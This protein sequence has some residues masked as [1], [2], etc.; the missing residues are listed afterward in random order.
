MLLV[1]EES[2]VVAIQSTTIH[3]YAHSVS[4]QN[5]GLDCDE[6]LLARYFMIS[7]VDRDPPRSF[8]ARISPVPYALPQAKQSSKEKQRPL[9]KSEGVNINSFFARNLE[10]PIDP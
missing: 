4:I 5:H 7:V 8:G 10:T 9:L 2:V 6:T 1:V 3:V